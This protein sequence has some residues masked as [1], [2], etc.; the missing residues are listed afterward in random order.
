MGVVYKAEDIVLGR[1][2]ALNAIAICV[3]PTTSHFVGLICLTHLPVLESGQRVMQSAENPRG[4]DDLGQ[5][6]P[7]KVRL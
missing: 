2:V 5:V 7:G 6:M 3:L 4:N 1:Y